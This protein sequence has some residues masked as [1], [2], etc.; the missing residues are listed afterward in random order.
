MDIF[1]SGSDFTVQLHDFNGG[2]AASG[3]FWTVRVP[4]DAVQHAADGSVRVVVDNADVVDDFVFFGPAHVPAKVSF[5]MT[6]TPE[7]SMRHIRPT[8][9][10]PT[11]PHNWAGEFRNALAVGTFSGSSNDFT[12]TG[13]ASSTFAEMGTERNGFFVRSPVH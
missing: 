7:G 6:F 13:S 2:I 8:S 9:A 4:D 10:D 12:F 3:L 5:D 1:E 11:D